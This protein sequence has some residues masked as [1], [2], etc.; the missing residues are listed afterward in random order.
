MVRVT[1]F[2]LWPVAV[3]SAYLFRTSLPLASTG[4]SAGT[5]AG[6]NVGGIKGG[7]GGQGGG[8]NGAM[9]GWNGGNGGRLGN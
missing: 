7:Q 6:A 1:V 4:M 3:F 5:I 8:G 9:F 2:A